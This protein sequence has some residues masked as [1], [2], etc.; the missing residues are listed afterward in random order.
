M[1]RKRLWTIGI[2]VL[3]AACADSAEEKFVQ[4]TDD[5]TGDEGSESDSDGD[6]DG[7]G[8]TDGD[9]DG[10]G[11]TDGDGDGDGDGDSDGD[12]DG[13]GDG[14][15]D[16]DTEKICMDWNVPL[17]NRPAHVMLLEDVS[18]SMV[19]DAD[20]REIPPPNKWS[21]AKEAIASMV[22]SFDD[23]IMFGLD[24]FSNAPFGEDDCS[25]SPVVL[26]DAAEENADPIIAKLE[27]IEPW[28]NT[29]IYRAMARFK[30]PDHAPAFLDESGRQFLVLITDGA[31]TCHPTD[32]DGWSGAS[33]H[34]LGE[35]TTELLVS[36][37]ISTIAIG[38][39][40][41]TVDEE[42]LLAIAEA[43]GTE[44]TTYL[45]AEDADS[46]GAVLEE[47]A[48]SVIG[49]EYDLGE[50]DPQDVDLE[51][52]SFVFNIEGKDGKVEYDDKCE[53]DGVAWR[54]VNEERTA[55][56]FCEAACDML[57]NH[58]VDEISAVI[59]CPNI[60]PV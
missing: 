54:W 18:A 20:L 56:E 19:W 14:D 59:G 43:G 45:E 46:L 40:K 52:V 2:G 41:T 44:F 1:L 48:W 34:E 8:D 57:K 9:G 42:Q 33:A 24:I 28:G 12:V 21:W 31:D 30:D 47:I 7:D 38:F 3:V 36:Y 11:D 6:G 16:G 23:Q 39:D 37:G 50:Y 22:T 13:D 53:G 26:M 5:S 60:P 15:G 51:N 35:L 58:E 17:D 10:D 29:P 49:C 27:E 32:P 25:V 55:V 4:G